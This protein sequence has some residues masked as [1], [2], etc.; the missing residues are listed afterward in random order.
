MAAVCQ[1]IN[2]VHS[3]GVRRRV[4]SHQAQEQSQYVCADCPSLLQIGQKEIPHTHIQELVFTR[5]KGPADFRPKQSTKTVSSRRKRKETIRGLSKS[6][7]LSPSKPE[8]DD[9]SETSPRDTACKDVVPPAIP[10]SSLLE[11]IATSRFFH[12]YVSPTRTCFRLDLD[13]TSFVIDNAA[14]RSTLSEA[15]IALGIL[16]LPRKSSASCTA[17]RLRYGR[18]LKLTN[19]ALRNDTA[20]KSDE[21]LMAVILLSFFEVRTRISNSRPSHC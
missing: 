6:N 8:Q 20:A 19:E 17:A 13:F 21:V 16:T 3:H 2:P 1:Q 9:A 10:N 12:H 15:V 7:H 11:H 18:A 5:S 4:V 14:M